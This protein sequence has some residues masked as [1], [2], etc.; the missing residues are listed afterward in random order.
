M[1]VYEY[2]CE[3]C[4]HVTEAIRRMGEAGAPLRCERCGSEKTHR[5]HS[6]FSAGASA[7]SGG[8]AS[9]PPGGACGACGGAPG[10]CRA[11]G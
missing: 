1:P 7:R 3:A 11:G 2:E 4:D 8:E 5:L 6:V 9:M 10:S